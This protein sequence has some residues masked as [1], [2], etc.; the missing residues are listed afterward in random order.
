MSKRSIVLFMSLFLTSAVFGQKIRVD[1]GYIQPWYKWD[2]KTGRIRTANKHQ[3]GFDVNINY[4]VK[5]CYLGLGYRL[6]R[7][8]LTETVDTKNPP[9]WAIYRYI[10]SRNL[11]SLLVQI[12]TSILSYRN[13][14]VNYSTG[15]VASKSFK[16]HFRAET[17]LDEYR[18]TIYSTKENN[19]SKA[20]F[21]QIGID[22]KINKSWSLGLDYCFEY[23]LVTFRDL[24]KYYYIKPDSRIMNAIKVSLKSYPRL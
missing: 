12:S 14:E 3:F 15:L 19:L 18:D 10:Y 20:V 9:T 4:K 24:D 23:K 5:R 6:T 21:Q 1:F 8:N 22:L 13:L 11:N 2:E 16:T 17:I 7:Q